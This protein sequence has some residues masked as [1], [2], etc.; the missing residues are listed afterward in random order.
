MA[1][2]L[3]SDASQAGKIAE[4]WAAR[5]TKGGYFNSIWIQE[6]RAAIELK[7]GNATRAVEILA[8]VKRYEAGW[9]DKY[10]GAYL[11]GQAYLPLTAARTLCQNFKKFSTIEAWS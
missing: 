2:A 9:I 3:A 8:P 4:K 10:M 6:L 11:R 5:A 1:L 7:Q